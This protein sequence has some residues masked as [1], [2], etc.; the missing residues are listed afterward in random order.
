MIQFKLE[1]PAPIVPATT[2]EHGFNSMVPDLSR[3][4][5][6]PKTA[7]KGKRKASQLQHFDAD[8]KIRK[9]T[10][11]PSKKPPKTS[12]KDVPFWKGGI[13]FEK[14][15]FKEDRCLSDEVLAYLSQLKN[16][17]PVSY[18]SKVADFLNLQ[19]PR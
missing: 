19:S 13:K 11:P 5:C 10:K 9:E 2:S 18:S 16:A 4:Q 3:V 8:R 12:L 15:V 17:N 7:Q 1:K 6:P 14:S